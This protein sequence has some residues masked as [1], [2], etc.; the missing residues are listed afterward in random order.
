MPSSKEIEKFLKER[1]FAVEASGCRVD[2]AKKKIAKMTKEL[3]ET[4]KRLVLYL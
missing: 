1:E 3:E 4:T 2:I